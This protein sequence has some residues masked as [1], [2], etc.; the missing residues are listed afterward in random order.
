MKFSVAADARP[1]AK[2][3]LIAT[4]VS[5]ALW[6]IPYAGYLIY[7]FKLFVTFVHEGSHALAAVLTN[8]SVY[9]LGVSPD[10]SGLVLAA[11]ETT[12]AALIVSSAGYVGATVFGALLLILIRRDASARIVLA[13]MGV[14]VALLTGFFGFIL[15][16][17]LR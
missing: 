13:G 16:S 7:P 6:F 10:T 15:S 5:I 1:Q 17:T 2:T 12:L 11:P 4:V 14:Y 3:L 9:S 8:S